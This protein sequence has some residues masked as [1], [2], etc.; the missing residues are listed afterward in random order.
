MKVKI[1]ADNKSASRQV[2]DQ[3]TKLIPK[4][5]QTSKLIEYSKP[6][7]II[8][9]YS[10]FPLKDKRNRGEKRIRDQ[11]GRDLIMFLLSRSTISLRTTLHLIHQTII[12]FLYASRARAALKSARRK[13]IRYEALHKQISHFTDSIISANLLSFTRRELH[14][15]FLMNTGERFMLPRWLSQAPLRTFGAAKP[16]W[17]SV[18]RR[19]VC[20]HSLCH[21]WELN[22]PRSMKN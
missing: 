21:V 1:F 6:V 11:R 5:P 7:L 9:L 4:K 13:I 12:A 16:K 17:A 2:G 8:F 22:F 14:S 18:A 20:W 10:N 15:L 3:T 19:L